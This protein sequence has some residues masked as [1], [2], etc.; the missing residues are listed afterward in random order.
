MKYILSFLLMFICFPIHAEQ[1]LTCMIGGGG[2]NM[3]LTG[4]V[5][6]LPEG[7][8]IE[9]SLNGRIYIPDPLHKWHPCGDK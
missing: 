8:I 9:N 5:Y 4:Y 6:K 3:N 7:W 1:E 2:F